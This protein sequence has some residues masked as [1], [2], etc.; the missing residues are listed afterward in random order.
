MTWITVLIP[1]LT[2]K[3]VSFLRECLCTLVLIYLFAIDL[4][5]RVFNL[6]LRVFYM[7]FTSQRFR[8]KSLHKRSFQTC[9]QFENRCIQFENRQNYM[10]QL[11]YCFHVWFSFTLKLSCFITSPQSWTKRILDAFKE[12]WHYLN[13]ADI[14]YMN[15]KLAYEVVFRYRNRGH[16]DLDRGGPM[17]R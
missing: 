10:Q 6:R 9:I 1:F 8:K 7:Q 13:V 14:W 12:G 11:G 3:E 2:G 16:Q 5:L 17:C 4:R 15:R